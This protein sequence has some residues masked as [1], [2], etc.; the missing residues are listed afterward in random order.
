[1]GAGLIDFPDV[2][3]VG[4]HHFSGGASFAWSGIRWDRA[5]Y[6][7]VPAATL[8]SLVPNTGIQGAAPVATTLIGTGFLPDSV[9][10]VDGVTT[11]STYVS[12]T[13]MT[14]T[15]SSPARGGPTTKSI[16]VLNTDITGTFPSNNLS[17][18]Y[19]GPRL[20][21]V[22]P[23]IGTMN[24]PV[25]L[26]ARGANFVAGDQIVVAGVSYPAT[27][28]SPTEMTATVTPPYFPWTTEPPPPVPCPVNISPTLSGNQSITL[29]EPRFKIRSTYP[30]YY[31]EWTPNVN[32]IEVWGWGMMGDD[33]VVYLDG[34][35][36]ST[37]VDPNVVGTELILV[38]DINPP[39]ETDKYCE[40]KVLNKG[41]HWSVNSWS[42]W[43]EDIG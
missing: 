35:P 12:A 28:V 14:V 15:V 7:S 31:S 34:G 6:V 25:L 16:R 23:N 4:Q 37:W 2:P 18:T 9:V 41:I 24:E 11:A 30:D 36:K 5:P 19:D 8:T 33:S 39:P 26:T 13:E 38:F 27:I 21:S 17:I 29:T 32:H 42:F 1:M 43:V 10:Q 3:T 22:T 40:I 20:T